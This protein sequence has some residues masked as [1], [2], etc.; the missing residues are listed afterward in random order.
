MN[1]SSSKKKITTGVLLI[2]AGAFFFLQVNDIISFEIPWYVYRWESIL[3]GIG[4]FYIITGNR[5]SGFLLT[6]IGITFVSMDYF[7]LR[8]WNMWPLFLILIGVSFLFKNTSYFTKEK[9]KTYLAPTNTD[10]IEQSC[11][12]GS[13]KNTIQTEH[14]KGGEVFVL[15]GSAKIDLSTCKIDSDVVNLKITIIFGDLKIQVPS[16]WKVHPE[17]TTVL[18]NFENIQVKHSPIT[19][20]SLTISGNI[21]FGECKIV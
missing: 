10:V 4:V 11:I 14:F 9:V 2:L 21:G 20:A 15:F 7:D 3:I 13:S 1:A 16:D 5:S 12:F 8:I 18:G 6:S 17:V 19:T